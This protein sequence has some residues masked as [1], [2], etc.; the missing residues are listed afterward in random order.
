MPPRSS[1]RTRRKRERIGQGVVEDRLHFCACDPQ[2]GADKDGHDGNREAHVPDDHLKLPP[3]GVRMKDRR[4]DLV[5]RELAR[6]NRHIDPS[7]L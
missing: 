5:E 7:S 2:H 6:S 1:L 4:D 3:R